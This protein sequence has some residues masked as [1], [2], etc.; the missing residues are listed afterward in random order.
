MKFKHTQT[1]EDGGGNLS[2]TAETLPEMI[3]LNQHFR[4][5]DKDKAEDIQ[6]FAAQLGSGPPWT[7]ER[8]PEKRLWFQC[9]SALGDEFTKPYEDLLRRIT[10]F[11]G[12]M[13][14]DMDLT[15]IHPRRLC[16]THITDRCWL[17]HG[18]I[19]YVGMIKAEDWNDRSAADN[20]DLNC[21]DYIAEDFGF[22]RFEREYIESG[23]GQPKRNPNYLKRHKAQPGLGAPWLWKA[24]WEWWRENHASDEQRRILNAADSLK[25]NLDSGKDYDIRKGGGEQAYLVS[26]SLYYLDPNGFCNW[27]GKG[28]M[29]TALSW[30]Q[31]AKL[32]RKE[33]VNALTPFPA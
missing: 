21:A 18:H 28:T 14:L 16:H 22:R 4:I 33:T 5:F 1:R 30:D 29:A 12:Q 27:D 3:D 11:D 20:A 24:I 32:A 26:F 17:E 23:N 13:V 19:C 7:T 25:S 8:R 9:E 6:A 31:F 15:A 2:V 10:G